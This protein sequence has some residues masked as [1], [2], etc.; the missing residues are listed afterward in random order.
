V[1]TENVLF[2]IREALAKRDAH[3]GDRSAWSRQADDAN[4]RFVAD[5]RALLERTGRA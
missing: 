2:L 5:V 4:H 1:S 3:V